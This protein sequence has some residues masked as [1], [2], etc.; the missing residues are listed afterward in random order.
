M[1]G[2]RRLDEPGE[3]DDAQAIALHI[4][5]AE[6]GGRLIHVAEQGA[7][8]RLMFVLL[9]A[10]TGPGDEVAE[11]Q[12][13]GELVGRALQEGLDLALHHIERGVVAQQVVLQQQQDPALMSCVMRDEPLHHRR[14]AHVEPGVAGVAA[15]A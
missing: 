12:R 6:R 8:E 9:L 10:E 2:Q 7:E 5:Q 11:R 4:G 15:P 1:P 14:L 13:S 3:I